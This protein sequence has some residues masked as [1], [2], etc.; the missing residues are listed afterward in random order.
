[1]TC[2][3]PPG[4]HDNDDKYGYAPTPAPKTPD[5]KNY[6]IEDVQ[7]VGPHLVLKVLYPNCK[8][9]SYEGNKVLVF[10]NVS[11]LAAMKWKIIDPHFRPAPSKRINDKEAPGPN[12]RFPATVEGWSDAIAYAHNKID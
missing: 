8:A 7:Q 5:A 3:H 1:M 2:K 9:C 11:T 10:L 12:A 6:Q 4:Y